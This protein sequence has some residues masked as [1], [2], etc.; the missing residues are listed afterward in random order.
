[1][2]EL[3]E[4]EIISQGLQRLVG[5]EIV[6]VEKFRDKIR[7]MIPLYF[8]QKTENTI[9]TKIIRRAKYLLIF[10]SNNVIIIIHLGMSGTLIM[11]DKSYQ[12]QKHDHLIIS[13]KSSDLLVFNDPRRFGI[14]DLINN[15]EILISSYFHA[16]GPEPLTDQFNYNYLQN[17]LKNKKTSI[18]LAIMDNKIVVGV[19]NIYASESLFLAKILPHRLCNDLSIDE[20]K[21]L[22]SAIKST[23]E[24]AIIAGGSTLKDYK[25][26]MNQSGYF[27]HQFNVY[28]QM[29]VECK[30]C[31][32]NIEKSIMGGR[33]TF[34]CLTCQK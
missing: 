24:N 7:Y 15:N 1:M 28:N 13:L 4:V 18:K 29:D 34:Y 30:Y 22:V 25:N 8:E 10:L 9:I 14:I 20:L 16:L 21:K 5:Q 19:G 2:P 11:R 6:K 33:S 17:K 31:K 32:N 12:K 26:S 23:L 3:P 27:Q